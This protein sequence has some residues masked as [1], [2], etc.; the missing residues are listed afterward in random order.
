MVETR[1]PAAIDAIVASL[2]AAGLTV[3]DG[4]ILSG[5]YGDAVYVGYDADPG[6]GEEHASTTT[7]AWAGLGQRKR[8]EENQI[9]CAVVTVTGDDLTA[10]KPARDA[11]YALLETVGQVL[12][13][14]P[15][16]ALS[17]PSVAE[18]RPGDY[19]QE[20]GPAGFQARIVFSIHHKTRV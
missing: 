17:P 2:K 10:W 6:I 19:F 1:L 16:L 9:T 8:D 3:W 11:A 15:S 20:P 12:R 14:D 5:D 4:P 7:Q 13:A 18:L